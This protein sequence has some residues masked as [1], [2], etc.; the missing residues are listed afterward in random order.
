MALKVLNQ[1]GFAA[2]EALLIVIILA[3]IGGTG[4]YVYRANSN[5]TDTQNAAQ[6]AANSA[7]AHKAKFVTIKEWD[8]RAPYG[9]KLQLTYTIK[10]QGDVST[11]LFTSS[12]LNKQG[13]MCASEADFGG[14]ITKYAGDTKFVTA[15]GTTTDQTASAYAATLDKSDYAHVGNDYFFY[16][17]PQAA[18]ADSKDGQKIQTQTQTAV[19]N[20]L[21]KL[22]TAPKSKS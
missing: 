20:L 5:T 11:A 1:K 4:Y 12:E 22:E 15:D 14:V 3:I 13:E 18:C 21:P 9:G 8:V 2:V 10:D 19:K 17:S 6:T 7:V 16:S